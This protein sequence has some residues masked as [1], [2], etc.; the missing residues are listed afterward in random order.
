MG[1]QYSSGGIEVKLYLGSK[2]ADPPFGWGRD[3]QSST[4]AMFLVF[5]SAPTAINYGQFDPT[6]TSNQLERFSFQCACWK[7]RDSWSFW[8]A[9]RFVLLQVVLNDSA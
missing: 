7:R 3:P 2:S 1:A 4:V 6:S 9:L 5:N 8:D